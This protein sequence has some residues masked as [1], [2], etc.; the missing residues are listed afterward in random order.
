MKTLLCVFVLLSVFTAESCMDHSKNASTQNTPD[1]I[2]QHSTD[3]AGNQ[4][5]PGTPGPAGTQPHPDS[6]GKQSAPSSSMPAGNTPNSGDTSKLID[7]SA[8][9]P[10]SSK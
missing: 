10:R 3:T 7:S 9:S 8:K 2:R 5:M 6:A 1:S 4:I